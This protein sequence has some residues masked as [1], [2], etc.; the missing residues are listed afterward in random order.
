MADI[1]NGASLWL[2]HPSLWLLHPSLWLLHPSLWLLWKERWTGR[3][4]LWMKNGRQPASPGKKEKGNLAWYATIRVTVL[5]EHDPRTHQEKEHLS[6]YS[7][8]PRQLCAEKF[9]SMKRGAE[10]QTKLFT[11]TFTQ[12]ES[13]ILFLDLPPCARSCNLYKWAHRT[14]VTDEYL[15]VW[16]QRH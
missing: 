11:R 1:L 3:I 10:C 9:K 12:N 4:A 5:E 15:K 7:R 8:L 16:L 2:L 14:R 6:A 13:L